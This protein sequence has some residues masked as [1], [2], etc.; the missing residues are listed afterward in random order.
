M[1]CLMCGQCT[2]CLIIDLTHLVLASDKLVLQR[3]VF[4][5]A[6]LLFQLPKFSPTSSVTNTKKCF[7]HRSL[8]IRA[9]LIEVAT[10]FTLVQIT[11]TQSDGSE[12]N[13]IRAICESKLGNKARFGNYY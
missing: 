7:G 3:K 5:S 13:N 11:A 10:L 8:V 12:K 9:F 2:K 1:H 4:I 6:C